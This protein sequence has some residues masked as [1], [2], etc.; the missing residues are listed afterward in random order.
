MGIEPRNLLTCSLFPQE[1]LRVSKLGKGEQGLCSNKTH[2]NFKAACPSV[3]SVDVESGQGSVGPIEGFRV[4][5]QGGKNVSIWLQVRLDPPGAYLIALPAGSS[6]F[7]SASYLHLSPCYPRWS[8]AQAHSLL[9]WCIL[10][11]LLDPPGPLQLALCG[12]PSQPCIAL[13]PY[14]PLRRQIP[15]YLAFH[16]C[17]LALLL[18]LHLPSF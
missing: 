8:F 7:H 15:N 16:M 2:Y 5:S 13:S 6:P 3:C 12:L 17:G 1:G 14:E 10:C 4:G 9:V 18:T 11:P